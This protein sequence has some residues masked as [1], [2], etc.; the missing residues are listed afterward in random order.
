MSSPSPLERP[1]NPAGKRAA[2]VLAIAVHLI[3]AAFLFYGVHWQTQATDVVE[4]ELVR[5][6]PVTPAVSPAP[7]FEPPPEPRPEPRAET[8]PAPPKPDIAQ[9]A[10]P[11]AEPKSELKPRF[12]AFLDQLKQET[13]R[14]IQRKNSD[15]ATAE[16]EK[17]KAAREA[18]ARAKAT[19]DYLSRI[20][21][22]IRGN[23]VV[24]PG[25]PGNPEA[26]FAVTQ[27]PG[28]EIISVR[29]KRS[30]GNAALDAAIE[31]AIHKSSPLPKPGQADVFNRDLELKFR[32]LE[33]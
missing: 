3:L 14:L 16:L 24:P 1:K 4:V 7:A 6:V 32:P 22:K 30:S 5:A 27:L 11:K 15:A 29:L 18:T 23:I 31:R 9:K 26:V 25:V 21:G 33:D 13:Q 19:A 2:L 20:R 12:D 17:E 8:R 28:G 10:E